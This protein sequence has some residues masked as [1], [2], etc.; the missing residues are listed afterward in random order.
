MKK[1]I[2]IVCIAISILSCKKEQ[3]TTKMENTKTDVKQQLTINDII[4]EDS[5]IKELANGFQFLEGPIWDRKNNRLIFSEVMG[6]K[7]HQWSA[8]KGF[9]IFLEPS[10]Y[11]GGN[12]FDNEGNIISCQGGA[13]Q[14][15]RI[16]P[17]KKTEIL[18][19]NYKGK[20]FNSPNDV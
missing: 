14:V 13:R 8:E 2:I 6:N 11:A 19:S 15:V 7:L 5:E 4:K 17:D 12:T 1:I 10:W 18:V 16:T 20:K 9:E 3:N